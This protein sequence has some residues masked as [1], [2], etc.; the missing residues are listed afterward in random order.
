MKR[1]RGHVV[2]VSLM[3]NVVYSMKLTRPWTN[4]HWCES[5]VNPHWPFAY[6]KDPTQVIEEKGRVVR[7]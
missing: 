4:Q 6:S 3:I 7:V 1:M 2:M 5:V